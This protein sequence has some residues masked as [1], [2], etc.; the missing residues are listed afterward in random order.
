MGTCHHS[1]NI[2]VDK[3]T[4]NLRIFVTFINRLMHSIKTVV[5][6]KICVVLKRLNDT[7]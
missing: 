2:R 3:I 4:I 1:P 5:N 7:H 6:V